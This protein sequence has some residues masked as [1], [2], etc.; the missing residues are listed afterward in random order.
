MA[1]QAEVFKLL[2]ECRG[3]LF[4]LILAALRDHHSAEEVM[5]N[6]AV[7]VCEKSEQYQSGT[8][9]R[10]WA[11]EIARRQ[12]LEYLRRCKR[13]PQAISPSDLDYLVTAF[14]EVD[15]EGLMVDRAEALRKCL[16]K[17]PTNVRQLLHFRYS[18]QLSL[19]EIALRAGQEIESV[20]KSMY[21][22]R[23]ALK[24]CIDSRLRL[25]RQGHG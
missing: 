19:A 1:A 17:S 7:V 2:I 15:R 20:R 23:M 8:S 5:Q 22:G 18:E 4:A 25:T 9:F 21:R 11:R 10:A 24:R 12:I 13:G 3:D 16:E 14:E 6:V